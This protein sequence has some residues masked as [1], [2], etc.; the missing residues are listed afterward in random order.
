VTL[1]VEWVTD[2]GDFAALA[3]E[4]DALLPDDALPFDLHCWYSAWWSAFG[5]SHQLSV[6]TVRRGEELA[7]VLPLFR[8]GRDL[9]ALADV[10]SPSF[11][12]LAR[13]GEAMSALIAAAMD[14]GAARL[15]LVGIPCGDAC[16]AQL[17]SGARRA[18]RIP[19]IEP[20]EVSPF[21]D[22]EGEFDAWRKQTKPRWGTAIERL[23]RK[24]GRDHEAEFAIVEA[25]SDLEAE[26]AD[27]FGVEASGW[28]G[29]A[30]T[31]IVSAPETETFY[32]G[33]AHAFHERGELRLSRISL[34][35]ATAAFD[36]CILQR[37]RLYLLK[38]GYDERFR[39][40]APGLVMRLSVIERCFELGLASHE[41]LG[42]EMAWK[43]KFAT[44]TRPH[45][46]MRAYRQRPAGVVQYTYRA[47]LRPKLRRAYG[48]L[49]GRSPSGAGS[50]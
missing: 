24:M 1:E 35:G 28:K 38:T 48:R 8:A 36:F 18:A 7:G 42:D 15:E 13:D 20:G 11:R 27:G 14:G 6:C 2:N 21:I 40:L 32:E 4:W 26:L 34:D 29:R 49:P 23:R 19:L 9:R 22:T 10:H 3:R 25:P 43:R 31:A 44:G 37:A 17:E 46:S 39:S 12:P 30:G 45:L 5:D 50:T 41:L 16:V 47:A 33:I